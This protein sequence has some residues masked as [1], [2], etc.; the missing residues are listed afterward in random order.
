MDRGI[1]SV[2]QQTALLA[3]LAITPTEELVAT[4]AARV[5]MAQTYFA[6]GGQRK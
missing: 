1:T 6:E 2:R 4:S 3:D 5:E